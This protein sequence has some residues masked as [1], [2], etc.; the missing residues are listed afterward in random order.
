MTKCRAHS[1][2]VA[3]RCACRRSP[4]GEN[5]AV[6]M[7][8]S[9][10]SFSLPDDDKD[11]KGVDDARGGSLGAGEPALNARPPGVRSIN[12]NEIFFDLSEDI[13][14]D[15][16]I[17]V[18]LSLPET[19]WN[20]F[21]FFWARPTG[22]TAGTKYRS[23]PFVSGKCPPLKAKSV[24]P[25]TFGTFTHVQIVDLCVLGAWSLCTL[26]MVY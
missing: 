20:C 9:T 23:R 5:R 15:N 10:S 6:G 16:S 19:V 3:P 11:R 4:V 1:P 2:E 18:P 12:S 8:S 17:S 24:R 21:V 22:I 13:G 25:M 7:S 14:Q 26:A